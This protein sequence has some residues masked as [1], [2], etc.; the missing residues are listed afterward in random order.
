METPVIVG[1]IEVTTLAVAG[2]VACSARLRRAFGL[3]PTERRP[4]FEANETIDGVVLNR[5][6]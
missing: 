5:S 1:G 6:R 3:G 4:A 2:I